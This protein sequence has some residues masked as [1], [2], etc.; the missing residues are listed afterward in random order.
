MIGI[1]DS[2]KQINQQS[3][4]ESSNAVCYHG[5]KDIK[6]PSNVKQGNGFKEGETVETAVHLANKTVKWTVNGQ[7]RA[8]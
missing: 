2:P 6:W 5:F 8:T 3:S 7:V 4:Y 1:V